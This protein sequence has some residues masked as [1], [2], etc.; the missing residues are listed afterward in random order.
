MELRDVL[1]IVAILVGPLASVA[2]TMWWQRRKEKRDAKERLFVTLMAHRRSSPPAQDWVDSLNVI[3]VVFAGH[4][5]I[6]DLWHRYYD[7]LHTDPQ[8]TNYQAQEHTYLLMLAEIAR[9]LGYKN[10]EITDIDKFYSPRAHG[11]QTQ[12]TYQTQIEWLRVLRNTARLETVDRDSED[13]DERDLPSLETD[14]VPRNA[15]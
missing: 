12:L 4:T 3:D 8:A 6:L 13:R 7:A 10:L 14:G 2:V 1:T 9:L 15:R 11:D 5:K